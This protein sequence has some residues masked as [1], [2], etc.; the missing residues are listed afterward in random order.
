MQLTFTIE[1]GN[2]IDLTLLPDAFKKNLPKQVAVLVYHK[3]LVGFANVFIENNSLKATAEIPDELL[4]L[5]PVPVFEIDDEK[6]LE[7][8]KT[9]LVTEAT[10]L[11]IGLMPHKNGDAVKS[12]QQQRL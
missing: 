11:S 2:Q 6:L 12:L 3:Q 1:L 4:I 8:G 9:T 10:L 7:D 5:A